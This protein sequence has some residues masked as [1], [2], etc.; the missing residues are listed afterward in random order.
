MTTNNETADA[1]FRYENIIVDQ[2]YDENDEKGVAFKKVADL[3]GQTWKVKSG[4]EGI[5]KA[6][7]GLLV[8]SKALRLTIA[9]FK[10][11]DYVANVESITDLAEAEA[12]RRLQMMMRDLKNESIEAQKASDLINQL[13]I[14][15][16]N[17][18]GFKILSDNSFVAN[19]DTIMGLIA[20]KDNWLRHALRNYAP[21][22]VTE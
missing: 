5:L 12:T 3:A 21:K 16:L 17:N 1:G 4:K 8:H 18:G 20:A 7:W 6:K 13:Q 15:I 19:A 2:V 11:Y 10:G 22:E 14:A 9:K